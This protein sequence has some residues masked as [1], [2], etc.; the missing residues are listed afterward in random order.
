MLPTNEDFL[1]SCARWNGK[2]NGIRYEL[3]WHGRSDYSPQGTWCY[4]IYVTSEEFFPEDWQL[5]RLSHEDKQLSPESSYRRWFNYDDFPDLEPHGGWTF[6]EMDTYCGRD[7]TEQEQVKVGCDY[8]HL[9]DREGG[10]WQGRAA[11]EH[12]AKNSIDLLCKMFPN[13]RLCCAYSGKYD[14]ADQFYTARNGAV[15]H[16]SQLSKFSEAEWPTWL[17]A[18]DV[19]LCSQKGGAL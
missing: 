3:S 2:H 17:P 7:G 13:R 1:D 12:D 11:I 14:A 19:A 4:Y 9:W 16:K 8:A 18:D 6:G 5:L 15:V 10:Y